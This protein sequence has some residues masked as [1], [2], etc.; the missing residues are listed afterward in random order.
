MEI[1]DWAKEELKS[2]H[3]GQ[4]LVAW[5]IIEA[6]TKASPNYLEKFGDFDGSNLQVEMKINGIEVPVME[7]LELIEEQ[8]DALVL[9]K[10]KKLVEEKFYHHENVLLALKEHV[11]GQLQD[12]Y[13]KD[14][15][16]SVEPDTRSSV[17][18]LGSDAS[19]G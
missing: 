3:E 8:L 5:L 9:D 11:L 4:G 17:E 18:S 12:G 1:I 15:L 13:T 19:A 16:T 2:S 7:T 6:M 10:A 14:S